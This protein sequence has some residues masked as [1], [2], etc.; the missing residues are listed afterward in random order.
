ME[1]A[2]RALDNDS[3]VLLVSEDSIAREVLRQTLMVHLIEG[4]AEVH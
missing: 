2:I 3:R 4:E 1:A